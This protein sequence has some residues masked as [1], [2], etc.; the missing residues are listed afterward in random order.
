[1]RLLIFLIFIFQA[2]HDTIGSD[3]TASL[4]GCFASLQDKARKRHK[5]ERARVTDEDA[6]NTDTTRARDLRTLAAMGYIK[7]DPGLQVSAKDVFNLSLY[8]SNGQRMNCQVELVHRDE[9]SMPSYPGEVLIRQIG[10]GQRAWLL[11]PPMPMG[12]LSAR[13]LDGG[14][15]LI[16]MVRGTHNGQIWRELLRLAADDEGQIDDWVDILGTLPLPPLE[17]EPVAPVLECGSPRSMAIDVPLGAQRSLEDGQSS[18][19]RPLSEPTTPTTPTTPTQALVPSRYHSRGPPPSYQ[20]E[21]T[22]PEPPAH[23]EPLIP[24]EDAQDPAKP[25]ATPYRSDGAPPPPIH[26]TFVAPKSK[27]KS[28]TLQPPANGRVKRKTSSPLKHEYLPSEASSEA[29]EEDD[30]FSE[31]EEDES[32][33]GSESDS[34]S[35]EIDSVDIP[36]TEVGVSIKHPHSEVTESLVSDAS[37]TPSNSASQGGLHRG[38][39][40]RQQVQTEKYEQ[41]AYHQP[42]E[43]QA[44]YQEPYHQP[45]QQQDQQQQQQSGLVDLNDEV[46]FV[47]SVSHWHDKRGIWKDLSS[48][49]CSVVV[50]DGMMEAFSLKSGRSP[51]TDKPLIALDLTPVVLVRKSNALD[52]EV[53]TAVLGQSKIT[54]ISG[55]TFRFRNSTQEECLNLYAAVHSARLKNEKYM[56]LENEMR[57][58]SF[59]E[60]RVGDGDE[61][62]GRRARNWFGR[63]NSY[64]ASA[65]APARSVD[66]AS[67]AASSSMSA[68][69]FLKRL[70]G[71]ANLSFNIGRS[72]LEKQNG[73]GA[74]S[75]YTS[76]SSSAGGSTPRSPSV[77]IDGT[78]RGEPISSDNVPIRLHLLVSA[79]KWEDCGNCRLQVRRPPE[80]WRQELRANHGL[81][82]RVTV[83]TIPKKRD[84]SEAPRVVLDAVLGSGCFTT[85]GTRGIICSVWEEMRDEQGRMGH[86]PHTNNPGG[87]VKKWC[88]QLSGVA[89]ASWLLTLL[90]EEVVRA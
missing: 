49:M 87:S 33:L 65:R 19:N 55:G 82:K 62:G 41:T 34:S 50:S 9:P 32:D 73:G 81:E 10:E 51:G 54:S 12:S 45:Q 43:Y 57:F 16:V 59:G 46:R 86:I 75:F 56:Q 69:S 83:T 48:H 42:Q 70:T 2:L 68:S 47:C 53:R 67:T 30:S 37:L 7:I 38:G 58:K 26:R 63:K 25:N 24:R 88:F 4:V 40:Y 89:Q 28:S 85:M 36:D 22:A 6:A 20:L 74:M 39:H 14:R 8:H 71:G 5:E 29:E 17:L 77:S 60:R 13:K 1:M 3:G 72:S 15:E 64:R 18:P 78:G 23:R 79:S 90:H 27:S 35:D 44:Q 21:V 31:S 11:F 76:G 84:G 66:E 52:L 61:N 80:G